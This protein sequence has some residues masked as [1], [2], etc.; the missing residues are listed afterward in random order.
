MKIDGKIWMIKKRD[1][2]IDDIDTDMI[3]HNKYLYITDKQEMAQYAFCNLE[4]W[5]DFSK[6]A[7]KGDIILVGENFGCGSSRQHAV[8]CFMALGV[9]AI[10]AKSFGAIYKRN[11]INS[12]LAVIECAD[13]DSV[14]LNTG[15]KIMI[16]LE[17][18]DIQ[19]EGITI[20]RAKPMSPVQT[21]IYHA[22]GLFSY[23]KSV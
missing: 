19:L 5:K 15:D 13:L 21:N 7:R 11:A 22:G 20:L 4:G 12:A 2:L 18:G 14:N 9:Q 3:Y 8:D 6:K 17:N 16:N 1:Q 23:A 10:I